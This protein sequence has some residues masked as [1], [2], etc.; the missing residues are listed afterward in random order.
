MPIYM[1]SYVT[2]YVC[3]SLCS[4]SLLLLPTRS[5]TLL[6]TPIKCIIINLNRL[7]T[8]ISSHNELA[9]CHARFRTHSI[10]YAFTSPLSFFASALDSAGTLSLPLFL[11]FLLFLR[12]LPVRMSMN[13][14]LILGFWCRSRCRAPR[15]GFTLSTKQPA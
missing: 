3:P 2:V 5:I 11:V 1:S 10:A 13:L 14:L 8:D 7:L 6:P 12:I 15:S 4:V 9:L